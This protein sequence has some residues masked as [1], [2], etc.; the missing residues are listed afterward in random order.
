MSITMSIIGVLIAIAFIMYSLFKGNHPLFIVPVAAAIVLVFSGL[1]VVN[2]LANDFAKGFANSVVVLAMMMFSSAVYGALLTASNS[3]QVIAEWL[4]RIVPKSMVLSALIIAMG[5]LSLG[6]MG[7]GAIITIWIIAKAV[8]KRVNYS[9]HIIMSI[10]LAGNNSAFAIIPGSAAMQNV[11]VAQYFGTDPAGGPILGFVCFGLILV[12]TL[13]Y[14]EWIVRKWQKNGKGWIDAEDFSPMDNEAEAAKELGEQFGA[15]KEYKPHIIVALAPIVLVLV[16]LNVFKV[17]LVGSIYAGAILCIL[18]NF[19]ALPLKKWLKVINEG[20]ITA[21]AP[22]A[23]CSAL[24]G[25][26]A[27]VGTTVVYKAL[28]DFLSTSNVNPY[29]LA[30]VS[31]QLLCGIMGSTT[32]SLATIGATMTPVFLD[33]ASRTGAD[34]GTLAR[35]LLINATGLDNLPNNGTAVAMNSLMGTTFKDSYGPVLISTVII[36][37]VIGLFVA[38]PL[39]MF[40][41]H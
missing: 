16:L 34:M 36:P 21:A 19:K 33:L 25:F 14:L 26:G 41:V 22:L 10:V 1:N 37:L 27:V 20:V 29:L 6:G 3:A 9:K 23:A 28:T 30:G 12:L 31:G 13:I 15:T 4:V 40:G 35:V 18:L 39:A 24:A 17:H 38:I 2:G 11:M 7:W 8:C 32:G 5:I